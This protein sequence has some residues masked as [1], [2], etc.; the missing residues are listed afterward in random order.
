MSRQ[1]SN[2]AG[3]VL[4]A[5]ASRRLGQPKQLVLYDG[6]PLV[7][8]AARRLIRAGCS[9]V[10]TV[11]GAFADDVTASLQ[12]T[13]TSVIFNDAWPNGM[14]SSIALAVEQLTSNTTAVLISL[15]DQP[16]IPTAHLEKLIAAVSFPDATVAVSEYGDGASGVPAIF[17]RAHFDS[18]LQLDGDRGAKELIQRVKHVKVRLSREEEKDVDTG[19]DLESL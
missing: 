12:N 18:L 4:A 8:H 17:T 15:C 11:V 6:V 14:G 3:V 10:I 2:I 13:E 7:V 9:E 19:A 16:F 5:G 1:D